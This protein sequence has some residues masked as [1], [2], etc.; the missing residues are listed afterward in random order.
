MSDPVVRSPDDLPPVDA[1]GRGRRWLLVACGGLL[2]LALLVVAFNLEGPPDPVQPVDDGSP[3]A[4]IRP[5]SIAD[6]A[7]GFTSVRDGDFVL[8]RGGWVQIADARG[9]LVQEYTASRLEPKADGEIELVNPS[10]RFYLSNNRMLVVSGDQA[11]ARRRDNR[12]LESGRIRGNV[13]IALYQGTEAALPDPARDVPAVYVTTSEAVFDNLRGEIRCDADLHVQTTSM[14]FFGRGLLADY[15]KVYGLRRLTIDEATRPIRIA[16]AALAG[17]SGGSDDPAIGDDASIRRRAPDLTGPGTPWPGGVSGRALDLPPTVAAVRPQAVPP[18]PGP[19]ATAAERRDWLRARREMAERRAREAATQA[20]SDRFYRATFERD[21]HLWRGVES[22]P[23][24]FITGDV[25]RLVFSMD[26]SELRESSVAGARPARRGGPSIP[27]IRPRDVVA[28]LAL[29]HV[30]DADDPPRVAPAPGQDDVYLSYTGRLIVLPVES[31]EVHLASKDDVHAELLGAPVTLVDKSKDATATCGRIEYLTA[32][33]RLALLGT[34]E[35]MLTLDSSEIALRGSRF[36][37]HV[38]GGRGELVG[39]GT[40]HLAEGVARIE[41]QPEAAAAAP[42]RNATAAPQLADVDGGLDIEWSSGVEL[43]FFDAPNTGAG[44]R[45]GAGRGRLEKAIFRGD[46]IVNEERFNMQSDLLE[47]HFDTDTPRV[48]DAGQDAQSEAI[49]EIIAAGAVMARGLDTRGGLLGTD[50]LRILFAPDPGDPKQERK[51]REMFATG[52][53]MVRDAT[54]EVKAANLYVLLEAAPPEPR[55]EGASPPAPNR[56]AQFSDRRIRTF[57]AE[58]QVEI[59]MDNGARATGDLLVA[60]AIAEVADLTGR[61]VV[62]HGSEEGVNFTATG[63]HAKVTREAGRATVTLVGAGKASILNPGRKPE[64]E[65]PAKGDAPTEP[66]DVAP[67]GDAPAGP[68]KGTARG[69]GF[70]EFSLD[71]RTIDLA[72][73]DQLQFIEGAAAGSGVLDV[74]GQVK[75]RSETPLER[76]FIDGLVLT[77]EFEE[78]AIPEAPPNPDGTPATRRVLRRF[79]ARGDAK[80]ETH[81][82]DEPG[83]KGLQRIHYIAGQHVDY[84]QRAMTA[85]VLGAGELLIHDPRPEPAAGTSGEPGADSDPARMK[86]MTGRG[87]TLFQWQGGMVMKQQ[88]DERYQVVMQ[89]DVTMQRKGLDQSTMTLSTGLLD[90]AVKRRPGAERQPGL[91]FGGS[92]EIERFEARGAVL[93]N[94][95]GRR[96]DC[97]TLTYTKATEIAEIAGTPTRDAEISTERS[98]IPTRARRFR[99]DM[100]ADRVQI[101]EPSTSVPRGG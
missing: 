64:S 74:R 41:G 42:D 23:D 96:V 37:Y 99:W 87:T 62:V 63:T 68:P 46:V 44:Q 91:D 55:G 90:V 22:D 51:P 25:L 83:Y 75:A 15:D 34:D 73:T 76:N 86:G 70:D 31:N 66:S 45:S 71:S 16:G 59:T 100:L 61:E 82:W 5:P 30:Q 1:Y 13:R 47:V 65:P 81:L 10:G 29:T 27:V 101:L 79:T 93:F 54:Q 84:N 14:E 20:S 69:V 85:T 92:T 97:D 89:R 28:A 2:A 58:E 40:M 43:V 18:R 9:R 19:D 88:V 72:W 60:D 50:H 6:G 80:L 21:V 53:S 57:R 67:Q 48:A 8:E 35:H 4:E 38:R 95:L 56:S 12:M 24:Q 7:G 17:T 3:I 11:T 98:P 52:R 77:M 39:P 94:G 49:R 78:E 26:N 33:E 32:G 36:D